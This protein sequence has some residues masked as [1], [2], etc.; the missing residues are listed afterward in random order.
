[1]ERGAM[2]T[3]E[4]SLSEFAFVAATRGMTGAGLGLL[5]SDCIRT[6]ER[7]KAV[8]WTLL[9]IGVLTTVPIAMTLVSRRA[10][11]AAAELNQALGNW[12]RGHVRQ[13]DQTASPFFR[14]R[15]RPYFA[16][17]PA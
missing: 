15:E 14:L 17:R 3:F 8:G 13:V 6:V 11:V 7:R 2:K 1:M 5:L 9:S 10:Q 12:Q 4:L 16:T